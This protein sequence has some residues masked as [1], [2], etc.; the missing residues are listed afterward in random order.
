MQVWC[1]FLLISVSAACRKK[2]GCQ[3]HLFASVQRLN[4][5]WRRN[6]SGAVSVMCMHWC[7]QYQK[8][9]WSRDAHDIDTWTCQDMIHA[10]NMVTY[11]I[12]NDMKAS[13]KQWPATGWS[14]VSCSLQT[15]RP[16]LYCWSEGFWKSVIC[17]LVDLQPKVD[18]I[19]SAFFADRMYE[20]SCPFSIKASVKTDLYLCTNSPPNLIACNVLRLLYDLYH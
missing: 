20:L 14:G 12:A 8:V 5:L 6:G 1:M 4:S 17:I 7:H 16:E 10:V 18:T 15:S 2:C 19:S 9:T 13:T 3:W 11:N